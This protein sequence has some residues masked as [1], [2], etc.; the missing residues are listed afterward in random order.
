MRIKFVWRKGIFRVTLI[1]T[2]L[3]LT[4]INTKQEALGN[5]LGTRNSARRPPITHVQLLTRPE[6]HK[7]NAEPEHLSLKYSDFSKSSF[8]YSLDFPL[9]VFAY[10]LNLFR[11]PYDSLFTFEL[12]LLFVDNAMLIFKHRWEEQ[13]I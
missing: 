6:T 5:P 2:A 10:K 13:I 1:G 8:K 12:F 9:K 4:C 7:R 3:L 11:A